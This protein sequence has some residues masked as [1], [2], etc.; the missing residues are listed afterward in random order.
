MCLLIWGKK[1]KEEQLV[2]TSSLKCPNCESNLFNINYKLTQNHFWYISTSDWEL[3][4][5]QIQCIKCGNYQTFNCNN[6]EKKYKE[7]IDELKNIYNIK[8][9]NKIEKIEEKELPKETW[10]EYFKRTW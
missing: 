8:K 2:I 3:D 10:R 4:L 5:I 1:N 7:I 6:Y 9:D